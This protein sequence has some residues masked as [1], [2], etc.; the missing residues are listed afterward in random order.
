MG[1]T[2]LS[3]KTV[4]ELKDFLNDEHAGVDSSEK[5][6]ER[7][8]EIMSKETVEEQRKE[9]LRQMRSILR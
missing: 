8:K 3:R 9:L 4:N 2:P 5:T 1:A 7:V 6:D